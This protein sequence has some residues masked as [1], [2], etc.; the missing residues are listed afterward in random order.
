MIPLDG[1]FNIFEKRLYQK[2]SKPILP[3]IFVCGPPRSGT[4]LVAQTLIKYLPVYYF[5]N[6]TSIFPNSPIIANKVFRRFNITKNKSLL[7]KSF[8]GRTYGIWEPN[9]ALYLWDRW[10]GVD[11]DLIPKSISPQN[12]RKMVSFFAA[13]EKYSNKPL[14]NKNNKLNT[15]AHLVSNAMDTAYFICLDR[16]PVYLAQSLLIARRFI[17]DDDSVPYGVKF[18]F[19]K[20]V[21]K[22][23]GIDPIKHVSNSVIRHKEMMVKQQNLIGEKRFIIIPYEDFCREPAKWVNIISE[24]VLGASLDVQKL[25]EELKPY[26]VSNKIKLDITEFNQINKN[27]EHLKMSYDQREK[28]RTVE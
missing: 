15:Y 7:I 13:V 14:L 27:L 28:Q 1:I 9:D 25:K 6:L 4:T 5:N 17:H 3:Q 21:R 11:R 12:E 24:K 23:D 22:G 16:D 19:P 20:K 2:D 26:P 18:N 8:Y 10:T